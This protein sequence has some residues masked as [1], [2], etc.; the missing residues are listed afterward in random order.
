MKELFE[1]SRD[2]L[3]KE[4]RGY[5]FGWANRSKGKEWVPVNTA[6]LLLFLNRNEE[7]IKDYYFTKD[8]DTV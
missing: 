8:K 5:P 2:R 1:T 4:I 3:L 7:S 6:S